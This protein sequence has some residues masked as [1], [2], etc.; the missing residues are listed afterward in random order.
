MNKDVVSCDV[1]DKSVKTS[2]GSTS[3]LFGHLETH[4]PTQYAAV[5]SKG[6]TPAASRKRKLDASSSKATNQP[7]LLSMIPYNKGNA[8]HATIVEAV[9]RY[10]TS[11]CAA[12]YTVEKQ[13]FIDLLKVL[14]PRFQC[15]G[16]N[17]FSQT[18]IPSAYMK[19]KA[20]VAEEL[21]VPYVSLTTDGWSSLA[22]DPYISLTT[23]FIDDTW[24]LKTRC[25]STMYAPDSHTADNL[26]QFTKAGLEEFGLY[27]INTVAM[28]TDS[29]ANMIA[30]CKN[31]GV[32]RVSCFGHILHNAVSTT[33]DK[34]Q[35][36]ISLL[37]ASRKIVSVFSF[38]F[39]F[40]SSLKKAQKE[41]NLPSTQLVNDVCT[42]WGSK[43][44]MLERLQTQLPA[45]EK[46]FNDG[47]SATSMAAWPVCL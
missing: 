44:N 26:A 21:K 18:A 33:L 32:Q 14:D 20:Q 17:H 2:Q 22:K 36:I 38:S 47:E 35:P 24:T 11:G 7:T 28:T 12:M 10:L 9:T 30:A 15:P 19:L 4:H 40:R 6:T 13:S 42:R 34:N 31:L 1:C 8:R 25:L 3:N 27:I 46:L 41:L 45:V 43:L 37:R 23:H 29:A 5:A 16:R 39:K